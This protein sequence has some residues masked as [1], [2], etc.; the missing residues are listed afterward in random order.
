MSVKKRAK[1]IY[2][3]GH[4]HAKK[5]AQ[6]GTA[7][8]FALILFVGILLPAGVG[9]AM[10]KM[11][12]VAV[13]TLVASS[14]DTNSSIFRGA[15][16][17]YWTGSGYYTTSVVTMD[18]YQ[19]S[20]VD[21]SNYQSSQTGHRF[22]IQTALNKS[23]ILNAMENGELDK[24]KVLTKIDNYDNIN[25]VTFS[26]WAPYGN[27]KITL[28]SKTIKINESTINNSFITFDVPI[29]PSILLKLKSWKYSDVRNF[30]PSMV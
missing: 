29:T 10:E 26:F 17:R 30:H 27:D 24:I 3:K 11:D 13:H 5:I 16:S 4:H 14:A 6:R 8:M 9:Y 25:S 21:A 7:I 1:R 20:L 2:N 18:S 12:G 28:Y 23:A 22:V 15:H 19:Y